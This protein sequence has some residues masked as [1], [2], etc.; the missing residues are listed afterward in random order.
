[1][2]VVVVPM[3]VVVVIVA[4]RVLTGPVSAD[5]TTWLAVV[6]AAVRMGADLLEVVGEEHA[7]LRR[8]RGVVLAEV[9]E[10]RAEAGLLHGRTLRRSGTGRSV[11]RDPTAQPVTNEKAG[12]THRGG[13]RWR[14]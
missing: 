8:E 11:G 5:S 6:P 9:G 12:N 3:I 14:P 2:V 4:V 1:M 10:R 7:H 13:D